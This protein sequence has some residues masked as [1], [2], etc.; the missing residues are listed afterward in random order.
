[1]GGA[2]KYAAA[3]RVLLLLPVTAAIDL[4]GAQQPSQDQIKAVRQSCRSDFIAN[5]SSVQPGGRDAIECLQRNAGKLSAPCKSTVSAIVTKPA[6]PT[7]AVKQ[8]VAPNPPESGAPPSAEPAAS[9]SQE[10]VEAVQ[11]ACSLRDFVSHCSWIDPK[12]AEILL[13]LK[14]NEGELSPGCRSALRQAVSE[15][16]PSAGQGA[17]VERDRRPAAT[18]PASRPEPMPAAAA[19]SAAPS[20]ASTNQPTQKQITAVRAACRS[21]FIAHCSGVQPGGSAAMQC[22]QSH[23]AELSGPCK[24]AVA[25]IGSA[26][27]GAL[28]QTPSA[29]AAA[30]AVAPLGPLPPMRPRKA[31]AIL[32]LCGSEQQTLCAGIAPGGGRIISCLAD[33]AARLSPGCYDALA[34]ARR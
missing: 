7:E 3:L 17:P 31:L 25:A 19:L 15:P 10:A 24:T 2:F 1:M 29:A 18:A 32:G 4:A 12:S 20:A 11:K 26:A 16:I 14:A 8:T 34:W 23:S 27:P 28:S 33:N 30:P 22:L 9:P 6:A 21:D 5:C 13:C